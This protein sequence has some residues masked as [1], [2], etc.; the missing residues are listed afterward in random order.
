M[1]CME[2]NTYLFSAA[3]VGALTSAFWYLMWCRDKK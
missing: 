2:L 1:T 3:V